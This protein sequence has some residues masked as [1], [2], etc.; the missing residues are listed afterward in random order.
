[1]GTLSHTSSH[2]HTHTHH[3]RLHLRLH[4]MGYI[5]SPRSTPLP[6][7]YSASFPGPGPYLPAQPARTVPREA[8]E[9]RRGARVP[10]HRDAGSLAVILPLIGC[11]TP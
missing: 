2:T 5:Q 8:V 10:L 3:V 7:A 6:Y 9:R 11:E 1:M 4:L